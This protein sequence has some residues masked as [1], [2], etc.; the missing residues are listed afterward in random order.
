MLLKILILSIVLCLV[1]AEDYCTSHLFKTHSDLMQFTKEAPNLQ[2]AISG[3]FKA[4]HCCAFGY[5]S[6][7]WLKDGVPHPWP[8]NLSTFIIYPNSANQTIYTHNVNGG[9]KGNYTCV[10]KN[11][12][13]III[14]PIQLEVFEPGFTP[15]DP[16]ITYVSK[17]VTAR[18]G[19]YVRLFCEAFV[20]KVNLPDAESQ[21]VWLKN[22]SIPSGNNIRIDAV[23]RDNFTI[24]SYL[25]IDSINEEDFDTYTCRIT[26]PGKV[27]TIAVTISKYTPYYLNPNPVPLKNIL[28]L[29]IIASLIILTFLILYKSFGLAARVYIKD[30]S[31]LEDYVPYITDVLIVYSSDDDETFVFML[32]NVLTTNFHYNCKMIKLPNYI[33]NKC[34]SIEEDITNSYAVITVL[35]P[36]TMQ[37]NWTAKSLYA[38]LKNIEHLGRKHTCIV[39]KELPKCEMVKNS[40]G[41]TLE[42]LVNKMNVIQWRR[43]Q[44]ESKF[45]LN[46]RLKLPPIRRSYCNNPS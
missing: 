9:D 7:E 22:G 18:I 5:R 13:D 4:L 15:D 42:T 28:L 11:D 34:A 39:L 6:I 45:W 44:E 21:V 30:H 29:T 46:L 14:H 16:K 27:E 38:A 41:E 37:E 3:K 35:S 25:I 24:G 8:G 26:T 19:N 20:D 32:M 1:F 17:D 23:S 10:L 2:Y 33:E 36:T 43:R 31:I 12:T 40:I